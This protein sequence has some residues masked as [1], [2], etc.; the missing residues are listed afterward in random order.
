MSRKTKTLALVIFL[1]GALMN[2]PSAFGK[3][4]WHWH[5]NRWDHRANVRSDYRDLEQ[6]KRQLESDRRHH[7]SRRKLAEDEARI[8]DIERDIHADRSARR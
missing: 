5:N 4:Y 8:R 7:A 1:A 3:E 6:A 2:S